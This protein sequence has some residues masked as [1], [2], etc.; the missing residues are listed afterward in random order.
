MCLRVGAAH[1]LQSTPP[2]IRVPRYGLPMVD[3]KYHGEKYIV[4]SDP[5]IIKVWRADSTGSAAANVT[6]IQPGA[7]I[8][9]VAIYKGSGLI[10]AGLE[11]E[12]LGALG[13]TEGR[14]YC[15]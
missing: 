8:N 7:N 3:I 10:F 4:S 2:R 6:T 11:T 5:K 9:D 13:G 15:G 12:R 1:R 14:Q